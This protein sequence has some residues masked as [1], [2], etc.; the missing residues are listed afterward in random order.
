MFVTLT[1]TKNIENTTYKTHNFGMYNNFS[2]CTKY[3]ESELK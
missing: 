2:E 1:Y 3:R